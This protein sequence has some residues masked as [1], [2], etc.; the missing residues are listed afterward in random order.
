MT[1][2]REVKDDFFSRGKF[3]LGDGKTIRFW[4][5]TW[6][7]DQLLQ[8]QYP[9]LYNIT[10]RKNISVHDILLAAPPLNISFRR[11]LTRAN[12]A[13]WS[14]MSSTYGRWSITVS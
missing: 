7:G 9:S 11:S 14:N 4:E 6:L 10:N 8:A 5:D 12:W 2:L 13:A 1:L 3:Q